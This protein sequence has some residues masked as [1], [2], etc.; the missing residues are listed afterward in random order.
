MFYQL[1][2]A[3]PADSRSLI[4]FVEA[5]GS[6]AAGIE[7]T[8]DQF[9][10]MTDADQ[11]V[12]ACIGLE[13]FG[14][15]GLLRTLVVSDKLDQAYILSLFQ[16][17]HEVGRKKKL[18]NYYLVAGGQ[19]SIDFL[20]VIGFKRASKTDLPKEMA[21]SSHIQASLQAAGAAIMVKN[22]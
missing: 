8:I 21:E 4:E 10:M 6:N 11:R 14:E 16:S 17:I 1:K 15:N 19:G 22:T 7:E 2:L 3:E 12:A 13:V 20:R 18:K 9:V 5:A